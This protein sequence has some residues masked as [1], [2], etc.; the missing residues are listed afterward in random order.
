MYLMSFNP[1]L[2]NSILEDQELGDNAVLSLDNLLPF[3]DTVRI[4]SSE[5]EGHIEE[6]SELLNGIAEDIATYSDVS[7]NRYSVCF[8]RG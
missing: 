5:I 4:C 1:Q 6:T 2:S 7:C 8:K 3:R